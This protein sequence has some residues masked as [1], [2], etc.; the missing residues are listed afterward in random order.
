MAK[1]IPFKAVRPK[2]SL[3]NLLASRPFY[4]YKKH[5]LEAKLEGNP[6]SFLHVINP[7]FDKEDRSQP[8]SVERFEKVKEKYSEFKR[9][10]YFKK[11]K[12]NCLYIYRQ[13][14]SFGIFTG[15][16]GGAAVEDIE[17]EIIKPHEN[18]LS[19]REETF[20]TYLDTCKFHAEPVLLTY[21][22][23]PNINQ[24]IAQY[25]E[26][27]PEYEYTT[28]D[29]K[30]HELWIVHNKT[31]IDQLT[32]LFQKIGAI[33]IAD[34]HHRIASS[35]LYSQTKQ[36][37]DKEAHYFLS[38]FISEKDLKI[39]A[40]HRF[41]KTI[42]KV[43]KKEFLD[44]IE[45]NFILSKQANQLNPTKRHEIGM[46]FD[47]QWYKLIAK[48]A[49][50]NE[51]HPTAS[52][53]TQILSEL[54]LKPILGIKDL[55]TDERV[56]FINGARD[57]NDA[58]ALV[59][60]SQNGVA[61]ILYPHEFKEIKKVADTNSSMPPKSTWIEPKIRSGLTIYEL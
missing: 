39:F 12:N 61:F 16:I 14:T 4:T 5:L 37:K 17:K 51:D 36:Q 20:K 58:E 10:G 40:Y 21:K 8:N 26:N 2:R 57:L 50:F 29:Q 25:I 3:A 41:I 31:D 30:T 23:N 34:G 44:A 27:R 38:Y 32:N 35:R 24:V 46:Y 45:L 59:D 49:A 54:I 15:I 18:T 1:I 60:K 6:Y 13:T 43:S 7:E 55:K 19:K 22:D 33:Y 9:L 52:L 53:D 48:D 11:E 56:D 47:Q 42:G 28:T